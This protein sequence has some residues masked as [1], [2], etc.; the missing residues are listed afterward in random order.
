MKLTQSRLKELVHYNAYTGEFINRVNRGGLNR[1]EVT[2]TIAKESGYVLL[3]IDRK[4]YR[5]HRL[6]VLWMKGYMPEGEVDHE[7]RIRHDNRWKNLREASRLCQTRNT[8]NFTTNT[9]GVKGVTFFKRDSIW[10]SQLSLDNKNR[11]LGR[12]TD[13]VEAV[14]TRLAGEQCLDWEKSDSNSPAYEYVKTN[15]Q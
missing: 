6:A 9:S 1:G 13:F 4:T 14:A 3:G 5:A 11:H 8:P 12:S 10:I 15:I 2:G 7:N